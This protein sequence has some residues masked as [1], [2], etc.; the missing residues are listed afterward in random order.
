MKSIIVIAML[1]FASISY[2][3]EG[4]NS[5]ANLAGAIMS[6][7]Q[8]GV[9]MQDIMDKSNDVHLNKVVELLAIEAYDSPKY[10]TEAFKRSAVTEYKN[11]IYLLCIKK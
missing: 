6:A 1:V 5:I 3:D 7:R 10:L 9:P 4:C 11:Q 8:D 2:A